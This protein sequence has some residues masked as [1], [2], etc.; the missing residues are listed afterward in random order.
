[1]SVHDELVT[2]FVKA[3]VERLKKRANVTFVGHLA[4]IRTKDNGDEKS[5]Q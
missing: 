2:L 1:M 3:V 4:H 5:R